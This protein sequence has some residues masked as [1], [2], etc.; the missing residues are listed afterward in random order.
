MA[1]DGRRRTLLHLPVPA[2]PSRR[3]AGRRAGCFAVWSFLCGVFL[4]S[5]QRTG[6]HSAGGTARTLRCLTCPRTLPFTPG[7]N[8]RAW[9]GRRARQPDWTAAATGLAVGARTR[10]VARH[11]HRAE[12][13]TGALAAAELAVPAR[14]WPSV[15]PW[16]TVTEGDEPRVPP[17]G[18]CT[19]ARLAPAQEAVKN[20]ESHVSRA[21]AA[22]AFPSAASTE[23]VSAP[24]ICGGGG[25]RRATRSAGLNRHCGVR[26]GPGG[27][28]RGNGNRRRPTGGRR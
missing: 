20:R 17:E 22:P 7:T 3:G 2:G 10:W 14:F 28:G 11:S 1:Y 8:L 25:R 15:K 16:L 23:A 6:R 13:A 18:I 27:S 19:S 21:P 9:E 26:T 4:F 5:Y 12:I 24:L